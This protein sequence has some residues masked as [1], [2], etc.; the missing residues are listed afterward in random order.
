MSLVGK[1]V[2]VGVVAA[3][4][5]VVMNIVRAGVFLASIQST[6]SGGLAAVSFGLSESFLEAVPVGLAAG[7]ASWVLNRAAKRI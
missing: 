4:A 7:V 1:S 2:L 5:A 6:G 3:T